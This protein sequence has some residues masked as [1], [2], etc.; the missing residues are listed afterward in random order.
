MSIWCLHDFSSD[1]Q[2]HNGIRART[3]LLSTA[4]AFRGDNIRTLLFSDLFGHQVPV[5]ELGEDKSLFVSQC[6]LI[7]VQCLLNNLG[8]DLSD[9]PREN[10]YDRSTR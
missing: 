3:M 4:T 5:P 7:L 10:K 8:I 9:E 6:F 2:V 1:L